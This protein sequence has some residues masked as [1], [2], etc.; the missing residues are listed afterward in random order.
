MHFQTTP[1]AVYNM[2]SGVVLIALGVAL[3]RMRRRSRASA[4]MGVF[5]A[6]FGFVWFV[7]YLTSPD[8]ADGLL[9][10]W[11]VVAAQVVAAASLLY[12]ARVFPRGAELRDRRAWFWA[13]G[14]G[15]AFVALFGMTAVSSFGGSTTVP[16]PLAFVFN[17]TRLVM[18]GAFVTVLLLWALRAGHAQDPEERAQYVLTSAAVSLYP[19]MIFGLVLGGQ[20]L[21]GT[22]FAV[23]AAERLFV[24][25]FLGAVTILWLR[26]AARSAPGLAKGPRNVALLILGT[27]A[28]AM[29]TDV[30]LGPSAAGSGPAPATARTLGAGI[31]AYAI[32]RHQLLGIDVRVRWTIKQSTVAAIFVGVFFVVSELAQQTF[33]AQYGSFVGIAAAGALLFAL[34]PLQ[35]FAERVATVAVP[36]AKP[37]GEMTGAQ[38]ADLYRTLAKQAWADGVLTLDERGMLDA[39]RQQLGLSNDEATRLEREATTR[40]A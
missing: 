7:V 12:L 16:E 28:F 29:L 8:D 38:R 15:A 19:A 6:A 4:R 25:A 27:A 21:R 33:S 10:R 2:L 34:A 37:V 26:T 20:P 18:I 23:Y 11:L 35:H 1:F 30:L 32:V 40:A 5:A 17:V 39:A 3:L 36:G 14:T 13:G 9:L 22:T 31:L 24:V